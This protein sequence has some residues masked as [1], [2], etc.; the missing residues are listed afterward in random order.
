MP[1]IH[2]PSLHIRYKFSDFYFGEFLKIAKIGQNY[3]SAKKTGYAVFC[4]PS[5][6][7]VTSPYK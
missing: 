6:A 5:P 7:M 4:S 1:A 3:V 2:S